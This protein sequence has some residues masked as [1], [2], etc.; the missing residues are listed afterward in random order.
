MGR[1]PP[2]LSLPQQ[3][4]LLSRLFPQGRISLARNRLSWT[5]ELRPTALSRTYVVRVAYKLG[6]QP[7]VE[8]LKPVFDRPSGQSLPHVYSDG[9]LCLH[10]R[11]D[12]HPKMFL[13][14]TI[15]PWASEWLMYYEIW[16]S[17][18]TWEGGG[19][20]PPSAPRITIQ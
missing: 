15:V 16:K 11:C 5:G 18:G 10:Q 17:T 13:A 14:D 6:H 12:W 4:L 20:W 1:R 19:E 9:S 2:G 7:S 3:A 8:V